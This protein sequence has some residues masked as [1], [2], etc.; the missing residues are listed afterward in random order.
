M[1]RV[2]I[3]D[4]HAIVRT[5][6][7][8][9][10]SELGD[11]EVVGEA[12]N[13]REAQALAR[14]GGIDVLLMDISMPGQN[15]VDVLRNIKAHSPDLRVLVLSGFPEEQYATSLLRHGASGYLNK[16]CEPG[17][18]AT[19]IRA[20]AAGKRYITA[21][22]ADMLA[23]QLNRDTEKPPHE[24]LSERELQVF[25]RLAKGETAGAIAESLALSIKTV[26][27]YRA[28][29]LEKLALSS[30]S[31]ITYYALKNGLIQ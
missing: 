20:V 3:V 30:N 23:G 19:A 29:I 5:G 28:R 10:F 18:I 15:G 2:A 17:E 9:F 11:I 31:D 6:L 16:E 8:Q 14:N 27:T 4:D 21:A 22:V 1:I 25:L 12:A 13:G 24:L 7:R 26:S